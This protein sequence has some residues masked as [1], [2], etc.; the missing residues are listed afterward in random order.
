MLSDYAVSATFLLVGVANSVD[1]LLGEH[2]SIERCLTQ[3]HMPRMTRGELTGI[4]TTGLEQADMSMEQASDWYIP[5]VSQGYPHYTHLLA[6][7][8]ARHALGGGR[9]IVMRDD[10]DAA[11][12]QALTMTE[13]SIQ[14]SYSA[15]VY[16]ANPSALYQ[17][18]LLACALAQTDD[19]DYF[20]AQSVRDPLSRIT[21]RAYDIP[22]FA[23]HLDAFCQDARGPALI[24]EGQTRRYRYRFAVPLLRPFVLLKGI[25]DARI[26]PDDLR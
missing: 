4:V 10:I 15:A 5:A 21:G 11:I 13:R 2:R 19:L 1:N 8:A 17:Q 3:V 6:L 12:D 7:Q 25:A 22:S 24:R 18:V 9:D 14:D 20:N 23:R 16:S 26:A